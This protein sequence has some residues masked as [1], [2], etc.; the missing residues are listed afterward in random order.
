ML[1]VDFISYHPY[2]YEPDQVRNELRWYHNTIE[3]PWI[4]GE[5]A[6]PAD[7]DSVPYAEQRAFAEKTL[8]QSR[9]CGAIGYSWWQYQDVKWGRFH[10]DYMGVLNRDSVTR[11]ASGALVNGTVK[12]VAEAVRSSTHGPIQGECVCLPNY[13]NYSNWAGQQDHRTI[14]RY[15]RQADRRRDDRRVD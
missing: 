9:A 1:L 4:V 14:D 10:A 5:T 7:N 15:G 3:V 11:T 8:L 6:I 12:P 2:E 13:L